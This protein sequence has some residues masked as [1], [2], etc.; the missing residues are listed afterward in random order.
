MSD[1]VGNPEDRFS[2][3]AAQIIVLFLSARH[4]NLL[5]RFLPWIVVQ[6]GTTWDGCY[7]IVLFCFESVQTKLLETEQI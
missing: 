7:T 3:V 2:R 4:C 6:T 1:L 5:E